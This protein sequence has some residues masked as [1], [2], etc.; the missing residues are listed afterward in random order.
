[1]IKRIVVPLFI[2]HHILLN[3]AAHGDVPHSNPD[4]NPTFPLWFAV[5]ASILVGMVPIFVGYFSIT[6]IKQSERLEKWLTSQELKGVSFG[7]LLFL[8]YDFTVLSSFIGLNSL[9]SI[10]R[11]ILPLIFFVIYFGYILTTSGSS[12]RIAILWAIGVGIHGFAEGVIMGANFHLTTPD[13]LRPL[14]GLSFVFHKFAEG[15][16][17]GFLLTFH[18]DSEDSDGQFVMSLIASLPVPVGVLFGYLDVSSF[19]VVIPYL[20]TVTL[21]IVCLTLIIA[22]VFPNFQEKSGSLS[23]GIGLLII[24]LFTLLHEI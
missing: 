22:Y 12:G 5:L 11:V 17:G 15:F 6:W 16:I 20:Y 2:F 10:K 9:D 21:S 13:V 7:L 4:G 19:G 23:A 8:F 3:V 24:Y 14:P 18:S 1:M